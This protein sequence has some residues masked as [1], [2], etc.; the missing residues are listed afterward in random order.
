MVRRRR[1]YRKENNSKRFSRYKLNNKQ[2]RNSYILNLSSKALSGPQL[3]VLGKGL[4]FV[5]NIDRN[6]DYSEG[7]QRLTRSL[8]LKY[9]FQDQDRD[10]DEQDSERP[11]APPFKPKSTWMPP[12]ADPVTE[13]YLSSLS[14]KLSA[15]RSETTITI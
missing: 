8:R 4:G 15:W 5:P 2:D 6:L 12:Q 14:D 10:Q 13:L 9:R 1:F 7:I 11:K 3:S